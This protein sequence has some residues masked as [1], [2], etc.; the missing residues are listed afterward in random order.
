L[1]EEWILY[2]GERG[3]DW[4]VNSKVRLGYKY[5]VRQGVPFKVDAQ[6]LWIASLPK[7]TVLSEIN[8]VPTTIRLPSPDE[9]YLS[10][11]EASFIEGLAASIPFPEEPARVVE[12]GTGK[13]TSLARILTGLTFHIDAMVWSI[14]LLDCIEAR[15]HIESCQIPNW[16]YRL[17]VGDSVAVA[18]EWDEPLD[19]L[20]LDGNH[21]YEGVLADV[22]AWYPHLLVEGIL[23]FHD[24]GNRKHEVT[25]AVDDAMK[26]REVER[27]ARVGYLMVYQ[28]V[29]Q[30]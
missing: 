28:R 24:Y 29:G 3:G 15:K 19:M 1:A 9:T 14:D 2:S 12:V 23:A 6:D 4:S 20:Y 11:W 30:R 10:R 25:R 8:F 27:V 18:K 22:D 21:S 7:M 5:T 13:G 26:N 17:L 16:R